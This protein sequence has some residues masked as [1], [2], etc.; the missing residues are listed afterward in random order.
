MHEGIIK[1]GSHFGSL[2]DKIRILGLILTK[3]LTLN[4]YQTGLL[5]QQFTLERVQEKWG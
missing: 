3:T 5:G 1:I 4:F 2:L